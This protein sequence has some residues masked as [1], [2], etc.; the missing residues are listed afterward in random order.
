LR[1]RFGEKNIILHSFMP[2]K[3]GRRRR[4]RCKVCGKTFCSTTHTPYYRLKYPRSCFD[5]VATMSVEGVSKSAIARINRLS[6]NTVARW[7]HRASVV[8]R[9]FNDWMTRGYEL[10]ELQ[11]DEIRTF[12]ARKARP[13]WVLVAIEVWSRLWSSSVV[14]RR[15]YGNLTRLL[16]DT[17][18]RSD[19]VDLPLITTDGFQYYQAAIRRLLGRACVYGQVVK[20]WRKDR[21]TRVAR[22]L[23]IGSRGQLERALRNSEDSSSLNTAFIERLNLT[24]RQGSAY[25][26]RR[27]PCH[28]R[29][30]DCLDDHLELLRS[31]YNFV[32]PHRA[33]KFG[34]ETRTP[35]MQAG[36]VSKRLSFR[37]IFM[38]TAVLP[39]CSVVVVDITKRSSN[40]GSI[41]LAA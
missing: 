4:Y 35:A 12:I 33:L 21:V 9:R 15:S 38:A 32:R 16:R 6:W 29:N 37:D 27:T 22:K 24:I 7:L 2:L 20:S 14:G 34:R 10:K 18:R 3:R 23:V 19:F 25:L 40:Y 8:A 1:G 30:R 31:Y 26:C 28:A 11:A 5:R 17:I 39:V 13:A 41:R 36:L